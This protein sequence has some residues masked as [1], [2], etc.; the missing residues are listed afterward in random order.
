MDSITLKDVRNN[1]NL[2]K[3]RKPEIVALS[4]HDS[5]DASIE[6]FRKSFGVNYRD[7]KVGEAIVVGSR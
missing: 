1:I 5:C 4:A 2:L 3:K 6:E 7:V